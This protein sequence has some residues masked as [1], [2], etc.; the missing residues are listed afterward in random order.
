MILTPKRTTNSQA[1]GLHH[2]VRNGEGA[3]S[4]TTA[5][6]GP[7]SVDQART[8]R[9]CYQV[10]PRPLKT[11]PRIGRDGLQSAAESGVRWHRVNIRLKSLKMLKDQL[12]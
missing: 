12:R 1:V 2:L 9:G 7:S 4:S 10:D 6:P 8:H 11:W 3:A 5:Q